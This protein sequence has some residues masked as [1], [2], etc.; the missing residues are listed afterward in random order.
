M[1]AT[2]DAD[3]ITAYL[4]GDHNA[5]TKIYKRHSPI[6]RRTA[7]LK[8]YDKH[9]CDDILQDVFLIVAK[10]L[11]NLD[12]PERLPQWLQQIL[13]REVYRYNAK[14]LR[15]VA[16]D[17][18]SNSPS[19]PPSVCDPRSEGALVAYEELKELLQSAAEGLGERDRRILSLLVDHG[20]EGND[21]ASDLEVLPK[22]L[23]S[24]LHR[25][26]YQLEKCFDAY[27][28][29]QVGR[30]SCPELAEILFRWS[31]HLDVQIRKRIVHHTEVCPICQMVRT[32]QRIAIAD[33]RARPGAPPR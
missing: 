8:L 24:L 22:D 31:G 20:V 17:F 13:V 10:K 21:L 16:T 6:L 25:M 2:S 32:Q 12:D 19:D 11:H 14:G 9:A 23:R 33:L 5:F 30:K 4:T 3:L 28:V 18:Q 15:S 29:A 1:D 26:R 27:C 7:R